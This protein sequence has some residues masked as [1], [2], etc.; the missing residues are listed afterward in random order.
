MLVKQPVRWMFIFSD[1]G[2][3][4][5]NTLPAWL[6]KLIRLVFLRRTVLYK[7]KTPCW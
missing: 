4:H 5:G 3:G 2:G 6:L 7:G 1:P